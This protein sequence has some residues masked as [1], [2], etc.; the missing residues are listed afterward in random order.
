LAT[1]QGQR[2]CL[3]DS[4]RLH[5]QLIEVVDAQQLA[6]VPDQFAVQRQ[7]HARNTLPGPVA[8]SAHQQH[9]H[10]GQHVLRARLPHHH[11]GDQLLDG[12][13]VGRIAA[14]GLRHQRLARLVGQP[15]VHAARLLH[16]QVRHGERDHRERRHVARD[17][18]LDGDAAP[19]P[20]PHRHCGRRDR[21]VAHAD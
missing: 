1:G 20:P 10:A 19:E 5:G 21:L 15:E 8:P 14:R 2:Y 12:H 18:R 4:S 6:R 11:A 3:G 7:Q 9:E 16:V 13:L 17:H